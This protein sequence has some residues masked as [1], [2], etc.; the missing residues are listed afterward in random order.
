MLAVRRTPDPTRLTLRS[1]AAF[2]LVEVLVVVAIL[3]ILASVGTIGLLRYLDTA[4]ITNAR[5]QAQNIEKA[6]KSYRITSD[7]GWPSDLTQLIG[8]DNQRPFLDGGQK[9]LIGPWGNPYQFSIEADP[10]GTGDEIPVVWTLDDRGRR[11]AW[12]KEAGDI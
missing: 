11:V 9:A 8:G 10:N 3:V 2:T 12:P 5:M 4:K 7:L 1:R 6:M